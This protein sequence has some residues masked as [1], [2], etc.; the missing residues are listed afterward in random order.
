MTTLP[1]YG[2]PTKRSLVQSARRKCGQ[3]DSNYQIEP[4]EYDEDIS[5]LN[6]L[7][8]ELLAQGI[9]LAYNF[10]TS[11]IGTPAD[12]SGIPFETSDAISSLLAERL[13]PTLGKTLSPAFMATLARSWALLRG[14][15][16]TVPQLT[17]RS[18]TPRGQGNERWR[19]G[20]YYTPPVT[21]CCDP[22]PCCEPD[23]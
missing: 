2:G 5:S 16:F 13:A 20:V 14:R 12:E 9:N 7:M 1:I 15:Y 3:R 4:E 19:W 6:D 23:C 17:M 21:E 10:P 22:D 8:A 11:N 18:T